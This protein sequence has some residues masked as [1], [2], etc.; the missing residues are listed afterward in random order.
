MAT[1]S[2]PDKL[3]KQLEEMGLDYITQD[4]RCTRRPYFFQIREEVRLY[5]V[6]PNFSSDGFVWVAMHDSEET[7]DSLPAGRSEDDFYECHYIIQ[8]KF[9]NC[10]LTEKASKRHLELNHYHYAPGATTYVDYA[11]RNP[12][13]DALVSLLVFLGERARV[14]FLRR[15][16]NSIKA[17]FGMHKVSDPLRG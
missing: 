8:E 10:F 16:L 7:Y 4:N 17:V 13:M 15:V 5:G 2:I 12:D 11:E 9:S 6:D 1:I 14:P 3:F